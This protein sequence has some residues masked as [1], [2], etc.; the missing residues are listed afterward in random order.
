MFVGAKHSHWQNT[1]LQMIIHLLIT[2]ENERDRE[3]EKKREKERK[4]SV[5]GSVE[6]NSCHTL[7]I[8]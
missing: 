4:K 2:V 1:D 3:K 7:F 5:S 8:Q 6:S